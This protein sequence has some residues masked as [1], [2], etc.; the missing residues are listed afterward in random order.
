MSDEG[1]GGAVHT[2]DFNVWV[3]IQDCSF[4]NN[5]S[6]YDGGTVIAT[7]G[8]ISLEHLECSHGH[9]TEGKGGCLSL[10]GNI[11]KL[12]DITV[13]HCSAQH[14]GGAIQFLF[15]DTYISAS[16]IRN[17]FISRNTAHQGDGGGILCTE[18]ARCDFQIKNSFQLKANVELEDTGGGLAC[19][20][21][22]QCAMT[23]SSFST[24]KISENIAM[25][26]GGLSVIH[27]D[28]TISTQESSIVC[29]NENVTIMDGGGIYVQEE[30]QSSFNILSLRR[31][32]DLALSKRNI[33]IMRNKAS[34]GGAIMLATKRTEIENDHLLITDISSDIFNSTHTIGIDS[35]SCRLAENIADRAGGTFFIAFPMQIRKFSQGWLIPEEWW[36]QQTSKAGNISDEMIESSIVSPGGYG[37]IAASNH[38]SIQ[39]QW[40]KVEFREKFRDFSTAQ[41]RSAVALT[42]KTYEDHLIMPISGGSTAWINITILD[43]FGNSV[44][45]LP[46]LS[47]G[48]PSND[49][50]PIPLVRVVPNNAVQNDHGSPGNIPLLHFV[51]FGTVV[52]NSTA[53]SPL[54]ETQLIPFDNSNTVFSVCDGNNAVLLFD[55]LL[56][57]PLVDNFSFGRDDLPQII[58]VLEMQG[59]HVRQ[60]VTLNSSLLI[61]LHGCRENDGMMFY[62]ERV[63]TLDSL[64][65]WFRWTCLPSSCSWFTVYED[66]R[67][68]TKWMWTLNLLSSL[69]LFISGTVIVIGAILARLRGV[70]HSWVL[71]AGIGL[72]MIVKS[73]L[74]IIMALFIVSTHAFG[75]IYE[76][77]DV[78]FS[79]GF[80]NHRMGWILSGVKSVV[81]LIPTL[82]LLIY[83]CIQLLT[84]FWSATLLLELS[85]A[86]SSLKAL[87]ADPPKSCHG[88]IGVRSETLSLSHH[89]VGEVRNITPRAILYFAV[90]GITFAFPLIGFLVWIVLVEFKVY[91][92]WIVAVTQFTAILFSSLPLLIYLIE[93][94]TDKSGEWKQLALHRQMTQKRMWFFRLR[95]V[96]NIMLFWSA[97]TME[98]VSLSVVIGAPSEMFCRVITLAVIFFVA[99]TAQAIVVPFTLLTL[100]RMPSRRRVQKK[101][102][103]SSDITEYLL[104]N[105]DLTELDLAEVLSPNMIISPDDLEYGEQLGS[106]AQGAVFRGILRSSGGAV[107]IKSIRKMDMNMSVSFELRGFYRE[108]LTLYKHGNHPNIVRLLGVCED[109]R[110]ISL[111]LELCDGGSLANLL[112]RNVECLSRNERPIVSFAKKLHILLDI[113]SGM[114]HLH[115]HNLI[116]RDLKPEN[117]LLSDR[118][119]IGTAKVA[120]LGVAKCNTSDNMNVGTAAYIAPEVIKESASAM[121]MNLYDERCDVYSFGV[122][123]Y[124]VLGDLV[125]PY[126]ERTSDIDIVAR[127]SRDPANF[128]PPHNE[129]EVS[130]IADCIENNNRWYLDLM[131]QCWHVDPTQRPTFNEVVQRIRTHTS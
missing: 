58:T 82:L 41:K 99:T 44:R 112:Q 59:M 84:G 45:G 91:Y 3:S 50:H 54:C 80:M 130:F 89:F 30:R 129:N 18:K 63:L 103:N 8:Y 12:E 85:T 35:I 119:S 36:Q 38:A 102:T 7:S 121:S 52:A 75:T 11:A 116:H 86:G 77:Q 109:N 107:A 27:S 62:Q 122:L 24:M 5:S 123:M 48:T 108:F 46:P 79:T 127:M 124:A 42:T 125:H 34:Y 61:D 40:W 90:F 51:E 110:K 9:S 14:G 47:D 106:G 29:L 81:L 118:E 28:A 49:N 97:F 69:G 19:T 21:G 53:I 120:D 2:L 71:R 115:A 32:Q 95:H 39:T 100:L 66:F 56:A 105:Q 25:G 26:G 55:V 65:V 6:P 17:I 13:E 37:S 23:L 104:N 96:L 87:C 43:A 10:R 60:P 126:G 74:I 4:N 20:D 73:I 1:S 57:R 83:T 31:T 15:Q 101:D 78:F 70:L 98:S 72:L 33:F 92:G 22:A 64:D 68:A 111:V 88:G 67:M 16:S 117:V 76:F 128:R 114:C 131:R 93:L 94:L 113:A